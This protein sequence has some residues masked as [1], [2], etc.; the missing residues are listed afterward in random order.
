[1]LLLCLAHGETKTAAWYDIKV[2]RNK[3]IDSFPFLQCTL[4]LILYFSFH[5]SSL[6]GLVIAFWD[7]AL[8]KE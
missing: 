5:L 2:E 1:M 3:I 7:G 4:L 8:L 6:M